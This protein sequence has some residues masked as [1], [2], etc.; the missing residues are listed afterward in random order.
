MAS[1]LIHGLPNLVFMA[2]RLTDFTETQ[3]YEEIRKNFEH[4]A[5]TGIDTDQLIDSSSTVEELII[6]ITASLGVRNSGSLA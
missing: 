3:I 1:C 6:K 5:L 4:E 2:T